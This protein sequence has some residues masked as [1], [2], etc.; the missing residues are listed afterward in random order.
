MATGQLTEP[1]AT[2]QLTEPEAT[3]QLTKS[4]ETLRRRHGITCRKYEKLIFVY[5]D[6]TL[7]KEFIPTNWFSFLFL[8]LTSQNI[9]YD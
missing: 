4:K 1:E 7:L 6:I 8:F 2:G 5:Y 3:G 9:V